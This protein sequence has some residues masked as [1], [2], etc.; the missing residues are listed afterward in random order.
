MNF[1]IV[2]GF[3]L[4]IFAIWGL[5]IKSR[6]IKITLLF[7][8]MIVALPAFFAIPWGDAIRFSTLLDLSR[9]FNALGIKNGL[10]WWLTNSTYSKEP[11]V[12]IY[13]WIFSFFK[14][15]GFFF[16][17]TTLFFLIAI[18]TLIVKGMEKLHVQQRTG[19]IVQLLVL[20]T[21]NI[22]YEVE[23][24]RNFLAFAIIAAGIYL[25]LNS[26]SRKVK[27]CCGIMYI[28]AL[29][30]HPSVLPFILLRVLLI[31]KN[32]IIY[33]LLCFLSLI[34]TV[35]LSNIVWIFSKISPFLFDK[36][37]RYLFGQAS[38]GTYTSTLEIIVT[39][40]ILVILIIELL[41]FKYFKLEKHI[42]KIYLKYYIIAILFTI[43]SYLSVQ[44]YL[45]SIML[46]LFLSI[47]IKLTLFS[48]NLFDE[49]ILKVKYQEVQLYRLVMLVYSISMFFYWYWAY[50]RLVLI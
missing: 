3:T 12:A 34:Y 32:K 27:I 45:R 13:I 41:V 5:T 2:Y 48:N 47:P 31:F 8:D 38:F 23:G 24:I 15:N 10:M 14:N 28:F 26:N 9:G 1:G 21:F 35:C 46:L 6:N 50:Y 19:V 33:Y 17:T 43:G 44:V 40:I 29:S 11:V 37:Q 4:I 18:T 49:N 7:L 25:D 22:F 16:Y 39:S 42:P 36:S 30:F 20:M